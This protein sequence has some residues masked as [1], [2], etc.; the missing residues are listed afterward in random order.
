MQ[1]SLPQV[2]FSK[3]MRAIV[4][5][6]MIE[7]GD[8]ILIGL[9]GGKDSLLLVYALA[10]MRERIKKQFTLCAFTLDLLFDTHFD[11]NVLA[12]Y[13]QRLCVPYYSEATDIATIIRENPNRSACFTCAYFRRGAI[14]RMAQELHCNKI[15]YAHH[16]D[17]A[18]ETLL[19]GLLYS[20]QIS[21]FLPKTCLSRTG[22]T[23]IRPLVYLRE[24]EIRQA[25]RYHGMKPIASPCPYN[26]KTARQVVKEL[27]CRLSKENPLL[28]PHLAAALRENNVGDLWPAAKRR[29]EMVDVYRKYTKES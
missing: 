9:S 26:G 24:D 4:E 21:T 28:Y 17:D 22:L 7:D 3:I 14:N 6:D 13:C 15:A 11:T 12:E 23:V 27:I 10:M 5:F 25:E 1:F 2:Y 18:V 19:M 8:H 20:G 16:N 29:T